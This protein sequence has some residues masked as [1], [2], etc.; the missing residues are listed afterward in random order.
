MNP[1]NW[2]YRKLSTLGALICFG[3][4]AYALY[5]QYHMLMLPCPLCIFQRVA[6][7]A[8]GLFFLI[9]A[10]HNP[11]GSGFRRV[12]G[13]MAALSA[14][15]GAGIAGRHVAIQLMPADEAAACSSLGLDYMLDIMPL[16][17]VLSTGLKGSGE[18]AKIDWTFL[19]FSMPMWTLVLYA[20]IFVL[21]I[22][23]S[24]KKY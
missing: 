17:E 20:G 21:A 12:Y 9:G 13:T 2:S 8:A 6:F 22:F 11:E 23:A 18:C 10:L 4:I 24:F 3:A 5:V 14:L 19:G 16:T 15:A 1:L 7:G